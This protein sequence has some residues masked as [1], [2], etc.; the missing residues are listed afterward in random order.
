MTSLYELTPCVSLAFLHKFY[1]SSSNLISNSLCPWGAFIKMRARVDSVIEL[2]DIKTCADVK[3]LI[4]EFA[5]LV[6]I[7]RSS[8]QWTVWV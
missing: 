2:Y 6:Y 3:L 8:L 5:G 1:D 4:L 7:G